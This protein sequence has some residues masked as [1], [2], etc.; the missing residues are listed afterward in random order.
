MLTENWRVSA[1]TSCASADLLT[2]TRIF[3]GL[4]ERLHTA[5]AVRPRL[6]SPVPVATIATLPASWR[7]ACLNPASTTLPSAICSSTTNPRQ[8][9]RGHTRTLISESD[10][11]NIL[12]QFDVLFFLLQI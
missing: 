7:I 2:Q 12:F 1:I 11:C 10:I 9:Q 8:C 6:C 4:A 3:A 5:V